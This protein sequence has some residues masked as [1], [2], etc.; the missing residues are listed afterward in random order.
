[1]DGLNERD[2]S[3]MIRACADD[4]T[5]GFFVC[6]LEKIVPGTVEMDENE[7]STEKAVAES[8]VVVPKGLSIYNGQFSKH[9][10][11]E[12]DKKSSPV[13]EAKRKVK[14]SEQANQDNA[15]SGEQ[16]QV[17]TQQSNATDKAACKKRGKKVAWKKRQIEQKQQRLKQKKLKTDSAEKES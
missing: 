6:C 13:D 15:I 17:K 10:S 8:S 7:E 4:D 12:A 16:P 1:M 5:N 2:A 11:T 9:P 3:C 14:P